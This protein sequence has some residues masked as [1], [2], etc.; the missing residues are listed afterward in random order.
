M[1]VWKSTKCL[2]ANHVLLE[3]SNKEEEERQEEKQRLTVCQWPDQREAAATATIHQ[4]QHQ[5]PFR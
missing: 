1:V 4:F 3:A 2:Q 5:F